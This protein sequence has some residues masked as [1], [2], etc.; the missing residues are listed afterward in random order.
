MVSRVSRVPFWLTLM[1]VLSFVV[2]ACGGGDNGGSGGTTGG[3]T[4]TSTQAPS[5][6]GGEAT[7]TPAANNAGEG[8]QPGAAGTVVNVGTKK[9]GAK[10]VVFWTGHGEPDLSAIRGIVQSFNKANPDIFV[11]LVQIPPGDVTDVS[12][13]MTAVRGGTGPDVYFMDR[14]IVAQQAANGL[15]QDLSQFSNGEDPLQGYI[16]FAKAEATFEGKPYAL[17][18]DTDARALY[19]RKDLLKQA[20]VNPDILDPKNGPITFDQL[21]DIAKKVDKKDKNGNYTRMGFIPWYNQGLHYGYGFSWGGDFYDE[22]NCKVTP[23]DPKIVQ[24]FEYVQDWAKELNPQKAQAFIQSVARPEAPP[25]QDPFITGRIAMQITGDWQIGLM[26]KYAPKVDYGITYIPVPKKGDKSQTWAGGWSVVIPQGAKEP[27]AAYKFM[28]Y[29]AGEPGQRVYT[30]LTQ[31][32]PTL[33]ALLKDESLFDARHKFFNDI[34]GSA[35]NRPPIPVGALYWDELTKA[36]E[37]TYL[38]QGQPQ[39][40]LEKVAERVNPQLQQYC[41]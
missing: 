6:A 30:K 18:F 25:Q 1:V 26:Q 2:A 4:G 7:T 24:A 21:R 22:Q 41:Q 20:G 3:A 11:K 5:G 13:V 31:H 19:Y 8:G 33:A 9:E 15:N 32:M 10:E 27:E 29:F 28:Q 34:I 39:Q 40:L 16:D 17:P 23:A 12:K 35:H 37:A 38:N 14:F 36:W